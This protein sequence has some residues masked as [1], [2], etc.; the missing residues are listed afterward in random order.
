MFLLKLSLFFNSLT[1]PNLFLL[2]SQLDLL[3]CDDSLLAGL[4]LH[5]D[6]I[7]LILFCYVHHL[8]RILDVV[9]LDVQVKWS[10][11]RKARSVIDLQD[12]WLS[13]IVDHDIKAQQLKTHIS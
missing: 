3:P 12:R 7:V 9:E 13:F 5:F 1:F 6:D 4:F 11:S 10:I 8:K 2:D